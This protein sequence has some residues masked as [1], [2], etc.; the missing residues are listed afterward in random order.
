MERHALEML[1]AGEDPLLEVLRVQLAEAAVIERWFSGVGFFTY[2][3]VPEVI[4]RAE[5]CPRK[6]IGDVY[7]EVEGFRYEAGFQL[8]VTDG[9]VDCLECFTVEDQWPK[10][11]TLRRLYYVHPAAPGSFNHR[12][13]DRT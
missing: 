6:V 7:A 10:T 8:F 9:T 11:A 12:G 3:S 1:L 2:L 4:P 5:N 13:N